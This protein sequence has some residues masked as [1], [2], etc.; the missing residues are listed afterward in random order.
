[1]NHTQ[2]EA[3]RFYAGSCEDDWCG[4]PVEVGP[5][6]CVS[7]VY[8]RTLATKSPNHVRLSAKTIAVLQDSGAFCDG[9]GQRLSFEEA[10]QRQ[11]EHAERYG[12]A[13]RLTHRASYDQLI[14]EKWDYQGRRYKSRWSEEAAWDAC[15]T[16][17]KAAKYLA[18]HRENLHGIFSAQGVTAS[19][20][21]ACVQG[22]LPYIQDG[23]MLGLGGFCIVG[24]I[25]RQIMPVFREII[26]TIIPFVGREGIKQIHIWGCL[27]AP[28]LGELLWLCDQHHIHLSTDSVYPSLRPVLGRWGYASWTDPTYKYRR[29]PVGP[30]LAR[31]RKTHCELVR[32]WL[33]H[34][35]AR[36]PEHYRW[37]AIRKQHRMFEDE[38][39]PILSEVGKEIHE[40]NDYRAM[41]W[42]GLGH[43]DTA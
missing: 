39:M 5:F 15:I 42:D 21:L 24:R 28:A 17:I 12:Y 20:Y 40:S 32:N 16:T 23:D 33:A 43:M 36:E 10:L 30:E 6:A 9:I 35:R 1:M 25:P 13:D 31:D 38:E 19:Q 29:P 8:G 14:D 3:V 11:I 2:T 37:R 41:R 34:F 7:P 4:L 22:I 27:Y 26:H 18:S